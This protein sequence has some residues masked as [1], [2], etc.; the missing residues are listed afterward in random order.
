[1]EFSRAT[2]LGVGRRSEVIN[3][4]AGILNPSVLGREES[5]AMSLHEPQP[6]GSCSRTKQKQ[7]AS[8]VL[9]FSK[10]GVCLLVS[11]SRSLRFRKFCR[12][13]QGEP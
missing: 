4:Q 11:V 10:S 3:G 2:T 8:D 5:T 13:L 9:F 7:G 1:M 12:R 6:S